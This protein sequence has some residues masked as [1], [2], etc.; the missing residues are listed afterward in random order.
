MAEPENTSPPLVHIFDAQ[1]EG[2]AA[3][4]R[5]LLATHD[6]E[7]AT[8][9][10]SVQSVYPFTMDGLGRVGILVSEKD[11]EEARRILQER[12]DDTDPDSSA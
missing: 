11:A 10:D 12:S 5:G 1:G 8:T 4:V 6:I 2:E 9:G 3:L 7:T